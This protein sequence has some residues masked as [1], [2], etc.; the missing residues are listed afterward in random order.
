[1]N[2]QVTGYLNIIQN[3]PKSSWKQLHAIES[4]FYLKIRATRI[5][6]AEVYR[7]GWY[8]TNGSVAD[9]QQNQGSYYTKSIINT[10]IKECYCHHYFQIPPRLWNWRMVRIMQACLPVANLTQIIYKSHTDHLSTLYDSF[11]AAI[12]LL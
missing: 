11:T 3:I 1:M 9:K 10:A 2:S 4:Q 8:R 6:V 5:S 7:R 12:P